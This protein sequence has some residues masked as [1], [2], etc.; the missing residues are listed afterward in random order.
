MGL[1]AEGP[2]SCVLAVPLGSSR[3]KRGRALT[4]CPL[5]EG[6]RV[7]LGSSPSSSAAPCCGSSHPPG[8]RRDRRSLVTT[9]WVLDGRPSALHPYPTPSSVAWGWGEAWSG[10]RVGQ[11]RAELKPVRVGVRS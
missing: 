6:P 11:G 7:A 2:I 1:R 3:T 10:K 4:G 8:F 9:G 5:D